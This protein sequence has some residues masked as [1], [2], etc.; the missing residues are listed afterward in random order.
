MNTSLTVLWPIAIVVALG[1]AAIALLLP[2]PRRGPVAVGIVLGALALLLAAI[3]LLPVGRINMEAI[4][5]YAFSGMALLAGGVMITQANPARAALSF[6]VV[7][8][9]TCGLF[10]LNAAPFLMAGTIIIYAGAIVVTFLFVLMLAQ[11]DGQSDADN[12]SREPVMAAIA[13]FLFLSTVL[14]ALRQTY[15]PRDFNAW[16]ARVEAARNQPPEHV[17]QVLGPDEAFRQ[18]TEDVMLQTLGR[19]GSR[20]LIELVRTKDDIREVGTPNRENAA[21]IGAWLERL[22][23]GGERHRAQA[24]RQIGRLSP[25]T[26]TRMSPFAGLPSNQ[27]AQP[28]SRENVAGLGRT[29]YSDY[30]LAV[31]LGGTLLLI[32]TIGAIAI[33][34]RPANRSAA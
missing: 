9:S 8:L 22:S 24:A 30:L 23:E 3:V 31:E 26:K 25:P 29:L 12:R 6:A 14:L 2:R 21:A 5:F 34:Q 16:L 20:E 13:G 28:L 4:L 1:M 18:W 32:A 33:T 15:E 17:W 10:L 7:I 27:P 11:P 19:D